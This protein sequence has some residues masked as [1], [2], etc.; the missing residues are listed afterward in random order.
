M[1]AP[2][3]RHFGLRIATPSGPQGSGSAAGARS[4]HFNAPAGYSGYH[5]GSR[6]ATVRKQA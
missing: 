1:I 3:L 4:P 5:P 6:L 2:I